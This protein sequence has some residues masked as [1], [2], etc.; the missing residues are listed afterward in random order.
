[1]AIGA[2]DAGLIVIGEV[3]GAKGA[4]VVPHLDIAIGGGPAG[5]VLSDNLIGLHVKLT[6][7]QAVGH[8]RGDRLGMDHPAPHPGECDAGH[9]RMAARPGY[10]ASN[11]SGASRRAPTQ[12]SQTS[13]PSCACPKRRAAAGL[14]DEASWILSGLL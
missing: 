14:A 5:F 13:I 10:P 11:L 6:L 8:G 3:I 7:L 12:T 4:A 1:M 9:Q 2:D